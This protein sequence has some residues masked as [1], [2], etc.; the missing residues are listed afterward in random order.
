VGGRREDQEDL[1][2]VVLD[3]QG[4][5]RVHPIPTSRD[6]PGNIAA[7]GDALEIQAGIRDRRRA[8]KI[9]HPP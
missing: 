7:L 1:E 2:F 3:G 6:D 5:L 8:Y 4:W 9:E